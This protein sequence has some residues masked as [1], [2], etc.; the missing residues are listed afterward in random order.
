MQKSR[1]WN[2]QALKVFFD[3]FQIIVAIIAAAADST[4]IS[5]QLSHSR[6]LLPLS[7]K[8]LHDF[9]MSGHSR[10]AESIGPPLTNSA[11]R[12]PRPGVL[13][14]LSALIAMICHSD[15]IYLFL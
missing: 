3:V 11:R 15:N 9:R 1:E 14:L 4:L 8:D 7:E 13:L 10:S 12:P 6:P 5:F 2:D